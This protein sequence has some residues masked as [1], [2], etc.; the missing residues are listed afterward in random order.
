M[1]Q[2]MMIPI[3]DFAECFE[4]CKRCWYKRCE[5]PRCLLWDRGFIA[6]CTMFLVS[7]IFFSKSIY[8]SYYMAGY[9]MERPHIFMK[10]IVNMS[11]NSGKYKVFFFSSKNN[12]LQL[13]I[14]TEHWFQPQCHVMLVSCGSAAGRDRSYCYSIGNAGSL[15][16]LINSH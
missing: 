2:L 3:K 8:F 1:G 14:S 11:K 13:I 9:F 6:L 7:P 12:F 15:F 4:W 16:L 10:P 5:V